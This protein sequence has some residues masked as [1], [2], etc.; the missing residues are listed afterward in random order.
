MEKYSKKD[1]MRIIEKTCC[2][3]VSEFI[4]RWT[5][6]YDLTGDVLRIVS[7]L[8]DSGVLKGE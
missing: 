2:S 7:K 6:V 5:Y 3:T 1:V 8:V 4:E